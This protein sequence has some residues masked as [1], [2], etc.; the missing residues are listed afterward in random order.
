[1]SEP[2]VQVA[3]AA[4]FWV[5]GIVLF[6]LSMRNWVETR[7][8]AHQVRDDLACFQRAIELAACGQHDA[9]I[10]AIGRRAGAS[11]IAVTSRQLRAALGRKPGNA[12]EV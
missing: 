2:I 6:C 8:L 11:D 3:L 9:A 12:E 4:G 7:A 10:T 5:S 1:M